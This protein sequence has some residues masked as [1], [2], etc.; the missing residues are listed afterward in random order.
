VPRF[1]D[2]SSPRTLFSITACSTNLLFPF[3]TN[4]SGF[5]SGFVISNTSVDPFGTASQRGTC[6]LN[7]YGESAA[8]GAAPAAQTSEAI[9]GGKHLTATLSSGGNYGL[10]ATPGFQGYMIAQ[11]QFQYGHGL[12]FVSDVGT[13]RVAEAYHAL[14]LDGSLSSRTSVN[15][16]TLGH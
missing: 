1:A 15:S 4:Q 14:V 9:P 5:D 2:G 16:E 12:A 13:T 8:G 7:Y 6:R 11:C 10:A 3:L